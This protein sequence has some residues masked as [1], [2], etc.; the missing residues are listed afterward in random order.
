MVLKLR[1]LI[2][3]ELAALAL[4]YWIPWDPRFLSETVSFVGL[5]LAMPLAA[6]YVR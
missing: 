6:L 3:L 1:V 4:L 2:A 5:A